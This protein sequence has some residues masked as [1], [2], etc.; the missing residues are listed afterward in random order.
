MSPYVIKSSMV[1]ITRSSIIC[2]WIFR[3]SNSAGTSQSLCGQYCETERSWI[4]FFSPKNSIK[5]SQKNMNSLHSYNSARHIMLPQFED[6][7]LLSFCISC[8]CVCHDMHLTM[9]KFNDFVW[10][11][12]PIQHCRTGL[13]FSWTR[14]CK[15]LNGQ[16]NASKT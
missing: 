14:I 3:I 7:Y 16:P 8:V 10:E 4:K 11:R 5:Y 1:W 2:H 15:W 13:F 12:V 9:K 6:R